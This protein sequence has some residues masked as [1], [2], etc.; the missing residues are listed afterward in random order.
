MFDEQFSVR[1]LYILDS[2]FS[3]YPLGKL[4][5]GDEDAYSIGLGV[6]GYLEMGAITAWALIR[7]NSVYCIEEI[8][9]L[10]RI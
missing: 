4:R 7:G 9:E 10:Q 3:L 5:G 2:R 1:S 8:T 6:G